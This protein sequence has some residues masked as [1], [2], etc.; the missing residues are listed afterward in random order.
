MA[1]GFFPETVRGD[2]VFRGKGISAIRESQNGRNSLIYLFGGVEN[3]PS[4]VMRADRRSNVEADDAVASR[5]YDKT[6]AVFHK[7]KDLKISAGLRKAYTSSG[8]GCA[9]GALSTFPQNIGRATVLLYSD[10][11]DTIVDPFAGHNSRMEL[12]VRA[13]RHYTGCDLSTD[14]MRFNV[15]RAKKLSTDFPAAKIQLYHC[16]S[17]RMPVA[18]ESGDMTLTSP[19]YW[20]IEYYGDEPKQLGKAK[21]YEGF[22]KGLRKT[23]AENFRTLKPEAYAV[24]FV[25]DFRK[26][27]KFYVYHRDVMELGESVGFTIHDLMVV[28]LGKSIRDCFTNQIIKTRI[29]PKRHEYGVVFRKLKDV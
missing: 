20:D 19:P 9:A 7:S 4:S 11:G 18:D 24:W 1:T 14:F 16:D 8:K 22:L 29:L 6:S 25:N 28:D 26:K 27:G 17:R 2:G 21:T 5:G 23:I 15:K 3:I 10:P 13:G 12:C